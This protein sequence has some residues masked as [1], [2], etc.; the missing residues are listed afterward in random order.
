M[1]AHE[2]QVGTRYWTKV[3]NDMIV[4]IVIKIEVE[5]NNPVFHCTRADTGKELSK[6][7]SARALHSLF[8]A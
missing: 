2:I 6:H 4:V 3:G 7:R 5:G 8:P 1:K